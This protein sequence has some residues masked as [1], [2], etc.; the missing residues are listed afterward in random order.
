LTQ[1]NPVVKA[2][3]VIKA[4][5]RALRN[6]TLSCMPYTDFH[7]VTDRLA[8]GGWIAE[9]GHDLP[10]DA[11]L[12][13]ETAASIEIGDWVRGGAVDYRWHSIMDFPRATHTENLSN[14]SIKLR[15]LSM[16]GRQQDDP[17]STVG[18]GIALGHGHRLVPHSISRLYLGRGHRSHSP[19][20]TIVFPNVTF[21]IPLRIANGEH[22]TEQYVRERI[23]AFVENPR[24]N[25]GFEEDP[26]SVWERLKQQGTVPQHCI[27]RTP[28]TINSTIGTGEKKRCS[29]FSED[30]LRSWTQ[31]GA[32]QDD[33][34]RF[35]I[36]DQPSQVVWIEIDQARPER[37]V[38]VQVL[39]LQ[40]DEVLQRIHNRHGGTMQ[41]A[42]SF[43]QGAVQRSCVEHIV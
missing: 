8:I 36:G 14:I 2:L 26:Q 3:T 35:A 38:R 23:A 32:H 29:L 25:H 30:E 37:I 19:K 13:L 27:P 24:V 39:G 15:H 6:A 40:A 41:K 4:L 21:E 34:Y 22:L 7:W 10:F 9:P 16:N 11:I 12:S 20:R 42:L 17:G 28:R 1:I 18:Q 33:P 31:S 43:Q 5:R